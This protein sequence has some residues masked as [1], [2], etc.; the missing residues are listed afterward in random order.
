MQPI[1]LPVLSPALPLT[2]FNYLPHHSQ[3]VSHVRSCSTFAQTFQWFSISL[4]GKKKKSKSWKRTVSFILVS[5]YLPA[6]TNSVAILQDFSS[7]DS[8]YSDSGLRAF[9]LSILYISY[10]T[11]P[12]ISWGYGSWREREIH[13]FNPQPHDI[14]PFFLQ[15]SAEISP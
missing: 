4:E 15:I 9:A 12:H 5:P 2:P 1:T 8:F 7:W 11:I 13:I 6:Y 14:L 3:N 10:N